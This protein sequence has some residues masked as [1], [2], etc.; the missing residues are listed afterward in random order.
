MESEKRRK[1]YTLYF[2]PPIFSLFVFAVQA[3]AAAATTKF[4]EFEPVWL[5]FL[6]LG[7]HVIALFALRA[8]QYNVISRH[9]NSVISEQ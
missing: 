5:R 3:M 6:I 9:I 4:I 8:L 1:P 2:P 7:R